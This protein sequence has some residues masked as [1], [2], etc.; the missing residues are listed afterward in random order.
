MDVMVTFFILLVFYKKRLDFTFFNPPINI[1][2]GIWAICIAIPCISIL[3][4]IVEYIMIDM[5]HY[6]PFQQDMSAYLEYFSKVSM[7]VFYLFS[8]S[9]VI[10]APVVEEIVFR[11]ILQN[12][13]VKWFG[14]FWGLV[15]PALI[16]SVL[17]CEFNEGV[18]NIALMLS[19]F[20]AALFMGYLYSMTGSLHLCILFHSIHNLIGC[21][22]AML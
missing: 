7:P 14:F 5:L 6:K 18:S 16:F 3:E 21:V 2:K 4:F 10:I 12:I 9:C 20:P 17:H 1:K 8:F 22:I 19:I 13:T 15:I 11:G